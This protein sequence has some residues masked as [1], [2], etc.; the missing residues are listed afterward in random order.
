M[1]YQPKCSS[2]FIGKICKTLTRFK[3]PRT[4]KTGFK[5]RPCLVIGVEKKDSNISSVDYTVLPISKISKR[6]NINDH[7]DH[8]VEKISYPDLNL[9]ENTSYIRTHKQTVING[10]DMITDSF[11]SDVKSEYPDLFSDVMSKF[12]NWNTKLYEDSM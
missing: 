8:E 5:S 3:N 10:R 7:Y 1:S 12:N 4:G 9:T 2:E 6:E 11:I